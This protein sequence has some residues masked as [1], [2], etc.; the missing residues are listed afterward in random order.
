MH[1]LRQISEKQGLPEPGRLP[2]RSHMRRRWPF[3][4]V[5]GAILLGAVLKTVGVTTTKRARDQRAHPMTE[6]EQVKYI[7]K[8]ADIAADGMRAAADIWHASPDSSRHEITALMLEANGLLS[9]SEQDVAYM[10]RAKLANSGYTSMTEAEISNMRRLNSKAVAMLPT[11][12]R[13]RLES[14]VGRLSDL[15]SDTLLS[16]HGPR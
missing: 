14:L 7:K 5:A 16:R 8:H 4:A 15:V 6:S 1:E 11:S 10:L 2:R 9:D 3:Y 13:V 12:D